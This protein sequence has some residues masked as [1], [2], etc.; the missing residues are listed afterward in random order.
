MKL[1]GL[2]QF[3]ITG[4]LTVIPFGLVSAQTTKPATKKHTSI[5]EDLIAYNKAIP[6]IMNV[7][8]SAAL[9][10]RLEQEY[11][12]YPALDLY[13]DN[14]NTEW[15]NPYKSTVQFPD[16]FSIDVSNY[17]MPVPGYKT[18]DYGP[19]WRRMHRGVD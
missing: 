12:E 19:R 13:G 10:K 1:I 6:R 5:Q 18:S 7:V 17:C 4:L 14:W 9:K 11:N 3:I 2:K 8:D 16:S 15:V